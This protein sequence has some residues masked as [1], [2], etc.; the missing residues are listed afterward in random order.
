VMQHPNAGATETAELVM[1][2]HHASGRA[3]GEVVSGLSTLDV[4][5]RV[6]NV[7]RVLDESR[8]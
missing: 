4:V 8:T 6:S 5:H 2:T 3:I 7:I 1:I